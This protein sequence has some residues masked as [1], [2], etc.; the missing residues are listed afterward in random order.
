MI[1]RPT[2]KDVCELAAGLIGTGH[3]F[4]DFK[5]AEGSTYGNKWIGGS[6]YVYHDDHSIKCALDVNWF[7]SGDRPAIHAHVTWNDCDPYRQDGA[8]V[9]IYSTRDTYEGDLIA[10]GALCL[11]VTG[12]APQTM[13]EDAEESK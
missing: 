3:P 13:I 11:K 7:Y 5:C 8:E 9:R 4:S 2:I 1:T 12:K 6:I 10:F